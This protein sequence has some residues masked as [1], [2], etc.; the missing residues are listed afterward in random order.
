MIRNIPA[1][2][3][4][5]IYTELTNS[6]SQNF[7]LISS[8]WKEFNIQL[9]KAGYIGGRNWEKFGITAQKNGR[10]FYYTVVPRDT[11]QIPFREF[12]LPALQCCT[13]THH[14]AMSRL[15]KTI[16][17]IYTDQLPKMGYSVDSNRKIIHIERYSIGF[18][19]NAKDSEIEI[20]V[21]VSM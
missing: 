17:G 8:L 16:S 1:Q 2:W 9:R 6:Q 13:F 11:V 21:P 18:N 15:S 19:W 12:V 7:T 3:V 14:G 5:G 10:M 4:T 20:I